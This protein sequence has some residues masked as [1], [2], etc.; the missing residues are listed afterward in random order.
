V[1]NTSSSYRPT[2][3][4]KDVIYFATDTQKILIDGIEYGGK[5]LSGA[6]QKLD[7]HLTNGDVI[8][9]VEKINSDKLILRVYGLNGGLLSE[10]KCATSNSD[11]FMSK[12][13]KAKLD[14]LTIPE[15]NLAQITPSNNYAA[16]YQLT[17]DGKKIGATINIPK[18][19]V[20][21]SGKVKTVTATNVPY[22]GAQIGDLYIELQLANSTSEP[23][24]IPANKLVDKYVGDKYIE[25]DGNNIV[26]NYSVLKEDLLQNVLMEENAIP[27]ETIDLLV[28]LHFTFDT[29]DS[30][31]GI[32]EALLDKVNE[33]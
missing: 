32:A 27:P 30:G 33:I 12:S 1:R 6:L 3:T 7:A 5:D 21:S 18:D 31:A 17:R 20:V 14:N 29:Y 9:K 28:D 10:I 2:S 4:H 25:V 24:Y 26:L 13:D 8:T 11:G 22:T 15:Y 16:S 19:M 23:I